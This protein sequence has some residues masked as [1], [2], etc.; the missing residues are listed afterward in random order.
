MFIRLIG[1]L[2]QFTW[3]ILAVLILQTNWNPYSFFSTVHTFGFQK[4]PKLSPA[5]FLLVAAHI[6]HGIIHGDNK[7]GKWLQS[8]IP[9][10]IPIG[11]V[12]KYKNVHQYP[13][14]KTLGRYIWNDEVQVLKLLRIFLRAQ[15]SLKFYLSHLCCVDVFLYA[16]INW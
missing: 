7:I 16:L 3:A 13:L 14:K 11:Y 5:L 15:C 2:T 1:L 12:P 4:H 9:L 10:D 6:S 8:H